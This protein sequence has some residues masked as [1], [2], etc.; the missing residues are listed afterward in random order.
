[1]GG[2]E[3]DNGIGEAIRRMS[4]ITRVLDEASDVP[5]SEGTVD[6]VYHV[7][8]SL[9]R[10]DY[11]GVRTGRWDKRDQMLQVQVAVPESM[12]SDDDELAEF[13]KRT[14]L[15][16]VEAAEQHLAKKAPGLSLERAKAVATEAAARYPAEP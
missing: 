3:V 14:L 11:E 2:P 9:V 10:P 13:L 16:A 5:S 6:V 7:P 12:R 15:E 1:M 4:R 8:G